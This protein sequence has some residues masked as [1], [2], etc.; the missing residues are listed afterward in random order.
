MKRNVISFSLETVPLRI[1]STEDEDIYLKS[2][3]QKNNVNK[4]DKIKLYSDEILGCSESK[5]LSQIVFAP[6][7]SGVCLSTA[8]EGQ[9]RPLSQM[10][11]SVSSDRCLTLRKH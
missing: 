6:L 2:I 5:P 10:M 1:I 4:N 11:C 8:E 7:G 9:Q 3:A